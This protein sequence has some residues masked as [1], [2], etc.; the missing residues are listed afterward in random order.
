MPGLR[1]IRGVDQKTPGAV[2]RWFQ[3][4]YF[5]L[6]AWHDAGGT[7][8]R[9]QLCSD[10]DGRRE[11]VIEWQ[12]GLG[13]QHLKTEERYA[14]RS[15]RDDAWALRLDAAPEVASLRRR[16]LGASGGLPERLRD[17]VEEKL[18]ELARP[19]RFRHPSRPAPFWLERLRARQRAALRERLIAGYPPVTP[20]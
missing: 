13:F 1:E 17:F 12:R 20:S 4:D 19:R 6:I 2:K 11:R 5:D 3:D 9:F 10:R 18:E 15:G 16:F 7:I 14:A 8:L